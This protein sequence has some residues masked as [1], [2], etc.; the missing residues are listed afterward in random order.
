MVIKQWQ[1]QEEIKPEEW[2]G[3]IYM[4]TNKE[5]NKIYIGKKVFWN[6]LKK[7]LT[8]TEY[9]EHTGRGKKPTHKPVVKKSDWEKY[10]GSNKELQEDLKTLGED[11]FEKKIL[12]LCKTKKQ[13]TYYELYFQ[14]VFKVLSSNSYN[15][16]I[17]GK[18]F[19][20]DLQ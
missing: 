14:C 3:F 6:N 8:K 13:L 11:I 15:S 17:L 9:L 19:R 4:I 5:T 10:W 2:F 1:Y 16:N 7:K 18:F 12:K 20:E